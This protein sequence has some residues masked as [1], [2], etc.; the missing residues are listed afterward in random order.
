MPCY[1]PNQ[2]IQQTGGRHT[3]VS[4][5]MSRG[6]IG[7]HRKGHPGGVADQRPGG[8][9]VPARQDAAHGFVSEQDR[10]E[11]NSWGERGGDGS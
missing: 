2:S 3:W 4:H 1:P 10:N 7:T 5:E 11:S 8:L 9:A 6:A